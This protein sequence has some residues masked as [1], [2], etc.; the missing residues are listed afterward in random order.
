MTK[1]ELYLA[2]IN[3][4]KKAKKDKSNDA[5]LLGIKM[6]PL[7]RKEF[8]LDHP[9]YL[10][11]TPKGYEMYRRIDK[12]YMTATL[13]GILTDK[14]TQ[15]KLV[16]EI[17]THDIRN[18]ED[19]QVW[20]NG[21]PMNYFIQVIHYLAVMNNFVGAIVVG[22]IRHFDYSDKETGKKLL[23]VEYRYYYLDRNDEQIANRIAY[24]EKAETEFWENNV[25]KRIPPQINLSI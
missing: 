21:I 2:I 25:L 12:P 20:L 23:N 16:L 7:I 6:E 22:R 8:A 5:T 14:K 19:E 18:S 4:K 3:A 13:D 15:D 11:H 24:V 9:N 17:K 10:V 1:L